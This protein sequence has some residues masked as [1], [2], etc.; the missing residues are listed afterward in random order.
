[1]IRVNGLW[2]TILTLEC[3]AHKIPLVLQAEEDYEGDLGKKKIWSFVITQGEGEGWGLE[4]VVRVT[5]KFTRSPHKTVK[6]SYYPPPL[7]G[8]KLM[9]AVNFL[10]SHLTLCR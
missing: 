8:S 1:M 3:W 9:L 2:N 4:D 10:Q 6:Y 7:V 5:I